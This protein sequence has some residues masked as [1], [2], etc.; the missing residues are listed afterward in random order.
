MFE[1]MRR[2]RSLRKCRVALVAIAKRYLTKKWLRFAP[3]P[4]LT[5]LS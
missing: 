3:E 1:M 4:N 2:E 5:A